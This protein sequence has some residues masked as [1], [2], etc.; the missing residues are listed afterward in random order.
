MRAT[1]STRRDH[2]GAANEADFRAA[3]V[4]APSADYPP[5]DAGPASHLR[6]Q[7]AARRVPLLADELIAAVFAGD[8]VSAV[9]RCTR[10]AVVW[11]LSAAQRWRLD[12][13]ASSEV[14]TTVATAPQALMYAQ[15]LVRPSEPPLYIEMNAGAAAGALRAAPD[16][17]GSRVGLLFSGASIHMLVAEPLLASSVRL[18][19]LSF[20]LHRAMSAEEEYGLAC[21]INAVRSGLDVLAWGTERLGLDDEDLRAFR[22][23][24]TIELDLAV[25]APA[26]HRKGAL[27]AALSAGMGALR[28]AIAARLFCHFTQPS[29]RSIDRGLAA[30][31]IRHRPHALFAFAEISVAGGAALGVVEALRPH[32]QGRAMS[33]GGRRFQLDRTS[34]NSWCAPHRWLGGREGQWRCAQCGGRRRVADPAT[35]GRWAG[36]M[37]PAVARASA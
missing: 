3:G 28:L 10:D 37:S 21:R 26:E 8:D 36:P 31:F 5:T 16:A 35:I 4:A 11:S 20:K 14:A 19:P 34:R 29:W 25:D 22:A 27:L 6:G 12:A 24:H 33:L 2:A 13:A 23:Q 17:A 15:A 7:R 1:T 9:S 32:F 18:L 30:A